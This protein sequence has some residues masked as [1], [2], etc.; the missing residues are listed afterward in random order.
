MKLT[1]L[2]HLLQ[3]EER[4]KAMCV[5]SFPSVSPSEQMQ[6]FRRNL[7]EVLTLISTLCS[8][9]KR[10][11]KTTRTDSGKQFH[12][13]IRHFVVA[14]MW[15]Y[16]QHIECCLYCWNAKWRIIFCS[17]FFGPN[18]VI[19]FIKVFPVNKLWVMNRT[20]QSEQDLNIHL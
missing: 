20:S 6:F 2:V 17:S 18:V 7:Y 5:P 14:A 15:A 11:R 3:L 19:T 4:L 9:A 10:E 16:F 8:C 12:R 1:P 13:N